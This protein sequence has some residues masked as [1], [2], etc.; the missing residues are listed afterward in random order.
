MF[1]CCLV[2][3]RSHSVARVRQRRQVVFLASS[4][5]YSRCAEQ[6]RSTKKE[7]SLR[8]TTAT[9]G[10]ASHRPPAPV[11]V[12]RGASRL[13][14]AGVG[15]WLTC[16]APLHLAQLELAAA[17]R[18]RPLAGWLLAAWL[19][20]CVTVTEYRIDAGLRQQNLSFYEGGQQN[21][22][23]GQ[24]RYNCTSTVPVQMYVRTRLYRYTAVR[25]QQN[26]RRVDHFRRQMDHVIKTADESITSPK[27]T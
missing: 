3:G 19:P 10:I 6:W 2:R 7:L 14:L 20:A 24:N 15:V 4:C 13:L 25:R 17:Q 21:D 12:R 8:A 9:G 5:S 1:A 23:G 27:F 16:D 11:A 26:C 22:E 18:R